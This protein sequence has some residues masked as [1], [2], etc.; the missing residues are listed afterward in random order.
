M[1]ATWLLPWGR[2]SSW[3]PDWLHCHPQAVLRTSH[4]N[5]HRD[6]G[7]DGGG[8]TEVDNMVPPPAALGVS[9]CDD[10]PE[11]HLGGRLVDMGAP[12][13]FLKSDK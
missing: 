8:N 11:M 9:A 12:L 7:K 2:V 3:C 5:V 1:P 4:E 13:I 10:Q 6:R